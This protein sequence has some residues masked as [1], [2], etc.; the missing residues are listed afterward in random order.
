MHA[1]LIERPMDAVLFHRPSGPVTA[2]TFL[3]H[4]HSIALPPCRYVLNLCT[5]RYHF[6]V[7]FAAAVLRGR[8]CLLADPAH[9]MAD[10][11]AAYDGAVPD[12]PGL[13]IGPFDPVPDGPNPLVALDQ[14][15]ALV[16]TS[17]STGAP[18][19]H[20]KSWGALVARSRAAG[21]RFGLAGTSVVGTVPP[22]HMY[23][24]E[25][26]VL[27][28]W[29]ADAASWCG[30]AFFPADIC[31]ALAAVPGPRLLVTTPMQMRAL[32]PTPLP[33]LSGVVSAT[34]PLDPALAALAEAAWQA[35]V[36]EIF[37]AT[38]AGSIAS[39]RTT[40]TAIWSPYPGLRVTQTDDATWVHAG[41]DATELA[42]V[43]GAEG[44]G[45]R[46]VG[47]RADM[48]K[49]AGRRASLAGLNHI[50]T[51]LDGV[52]DGAF[53]APDET[54]GPRL[55]NRLAAIVVAPALD[56]HAIL[57]GLRPHIDPVFLP[58]RVVHVDRL[59]R[60]AMGKLPRQALLALLE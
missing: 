40:A 43:T 46:L 13:R 7:V 30:P 22:G 25:T 27:L 32:L 42:D 38:E 6:A 36:H 1:P 14:T 45:F 24:L 48:V 19:P 26:T 56:T 44:D 51:G 20:A 28:P 50:L 49:L 16:F 9:A 15:A 58:R 12:L 21:E 11:V 60:N 10:T 3:A 47:R 33:G 31:A 18:V 5:D 35:P 57:A 55:T 52:L 2:G 4:A 59:P 54:A 34:A 39:R 8:I 17:G 37:G 53:V 23:G 41:R 29:H